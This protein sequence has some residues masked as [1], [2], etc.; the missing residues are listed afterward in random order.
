MGQV[1]R[2]LAPLSGIPDEMLQNSVLDG[3]RLPSPC[4]TPISLPSTPSIT[5]SSSALSPALSGFN[6]ITPALICGTPQMSTSFPDILSTRVRKIHAATQ[7]G[8]SDLT[9]HGWIDSPDFAE[10][11]QA[12]H[13][14]DNLYAIFKAKSQLTYYV[15][16]SRRKWLRTLPSIKISDVSDY[17][18]FTE[19]VHCA[20]RS[21]TRQIYDFFRPLTKEDTKLIFLCPNFAFFRDPAPVP[22]H[23]ALCA[24]LDSAAATIS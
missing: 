14:T 17:V 4:T 3:T 21:A 18:P 10:I 15:I 8:R 20:T 5:T 11:V 22:L 6:R 2:L 24:L 13:S 7:F 1:V 23:N 19:I 16:T 12:I 9:S